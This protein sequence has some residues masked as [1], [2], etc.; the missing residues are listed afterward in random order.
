MP[1][2]KGKKAAGPQKRAHNAHNDKKG[3]RSSKKKKRAARH[4]GDAGV[5]HDDDGVWMPRTGTQLKAARLR[6]EVLPH[7]GRSRGLYETAAFCCMVVS[8]FLAHQDGL[9]Y[10]WGRIRLKKKSADSNRPAM[11]RSYLKRY[12]DAL[13]LE[14]KGVAVICYFDEVCPSSVNDKVLLNNFCC[15]LFLRAPSLLV[16]EHH[17]TLLYPAELYPRHARAGRD[18]AEE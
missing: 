5:V 3:D 18:L 1:K 6:E 12:A 9:G 2:N 10:H 13:E 7:Q 14:R 4:E 15:Q 8:L 17:H 16:H 11:V